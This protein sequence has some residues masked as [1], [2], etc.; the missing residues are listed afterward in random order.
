MVT[1][2]NR[3]VLRF[4]A[5]RR[6]RP[7]APTTPDDRGVADADLEAVQ[8]VGDQVL[9]RG[10]AQRRDRGE[11]PGDPAVAERVAGT[12]VDALPGLGDQPAQDAPGVEAEREGTRQDPGEQGQQGDDRPD[13]GWHRAQHQ[14]HQPG[15]PQQQQAERRGEPAAAPVARPRPGR[16]GPRPDQQRDDDGHGHR[17]DRHRDVSS[18]A[19]FTVDHP[20]A[21][22]AGGHRSS[23]RV[24]VSRRV[25]SEA[26]RRGRPRRTTTP[27]RRRA[28]R[29]VPTTGPPATW[30]APTRRCACPVDL[31]DRPVRAADHGHVGAHPGA[32]QVDDGGEQ[33]HR[34]HQRPHLVPVAGLQA[35][36]QLL[37]QAADPDDAEQHRGADGALEPVERVRQQQRGGRRHQGVGQRRGRSRA[38]GT[39][40]GQRPRRNAVQGLAEDLGGLGAERDRDR[41]HRHQRVEAED[42]DQQQRPHQLVDR[43]CRHQEAA[44]REPHPAHRPGRRPRPG[45]VAEHQAPHDADDQGTRRSQGGED[46]RGQRGVGHE[47]QEVPVQRRAQCGADEVVELAQPAGVDQPGG[48]GHGTPDRPEHGH[49]D[50]EHADAATDPHRP[51]RDPVAGPPG[52]GRGRPVRRLELLG[53]PAPRSTG[54]SRLMPARTGRPVGRRPPRP[55]R[56]RR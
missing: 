19:A 3:N 49:H 45:D 13:G 40:R 28:R 10:G 35:D 46:H 20:P 44:Q 24:P 12:H 55:H 1:T 16:G 31:A 30:S 50:H 21:G 15:H 9:G 11:G 56:R 29:A 23:S 42:A 48:A 37:A 32:P 17:E 8:G 54:L 7:A 47:P 5:S 22:N 51:G 4:S 41:Q 39:Q 25:R 6:P 53:H 18:T 38:G 2:G 43:S 26:D 14:Q 33:Q 36:H 52:A 34:P 27:R